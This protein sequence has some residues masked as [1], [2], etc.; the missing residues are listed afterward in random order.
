M[1]HMCVIIGL[2]VTLATLLFNLYKHYKKSL[3]SAKKE[4]KTFSETHGQEE[5]SV[6]IMA[7]KFPIHKKLIYTLLKKSFNQNEFTKIVTRPKF[8]NSIEDKI[9]DV[10]NKIKYGISITHILC[11]G[12]IGFLFLNF[13]GRKIISLI[14]LYNLLLCSKCHTLIKNT[15]IYHNTNLL[16]EKQKTYM[17]MYMPLYYDCVNDTTLYLECS[18]LQILNITS[19]IIY[20]HNMKYVYKT[21]VS[22]RNIYLSKGIDVQHKKIIITS[23]DVFIII[24]N[25]SGIKI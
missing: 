25:I 21:S 15:I 16:P 20:K 13:P 19:D 5:N 23:V 12:P 22:L 3:E 18:V 2:V 4:L 9:N 14:K 6:I 1:T 7:Y 17:A 8:S 24:L 11:V 10:N